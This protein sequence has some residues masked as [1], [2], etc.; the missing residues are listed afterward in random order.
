MGCGC[1]KTK[2][3]LSYAVVIA[4]KFAR[5]EKRTVGVY[6]AEPNHWVFNYIEFIPEGIKIDR[7]VKP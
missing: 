6:M 7:I 5:V 1:K 4:K 2:H 3:S